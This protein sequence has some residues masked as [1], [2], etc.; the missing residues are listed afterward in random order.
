MPV[1]GTLPTTLRGRGPRGTTGGRHTG[2]WGKVQ[3]G[4]GRQQELGLWRREWLQF[5]V[6]L[7]ALK[8]FHPD[9]GVWHGSGEALDK[10]VVRLLE[11]G[12][13]KKTI[14]WHAFRR[15]GAA[16]LKHMGAPMQT[17]MI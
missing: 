7:R 3:K 9:R 16:Q 6:K 13:R 8:G 1:S 14:R 11:Q 15:L 4:G 17:I 5:L 12:E 2:F 10:T